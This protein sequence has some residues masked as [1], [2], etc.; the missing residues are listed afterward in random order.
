MKV[1]IQSNIA[2]QIPFTLE[3]QIVTST[4]V[5]ECYNTGDTLHTISA[6]VKERFK[7]NP[8]T[9]E[10]ISKWESKLFETSNEKDASRS[11]KPVKC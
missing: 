9:R 4:L 3:K 5:H 11:G 7:K 8:P 6:K 10:M 1:L 2:D